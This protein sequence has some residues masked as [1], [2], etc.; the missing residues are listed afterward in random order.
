MEC[1]APVR[2]L[3]AC[4]GLLV[5]VGLAGNAAESEAEP[6][7]G[8]GWLIVPEE[9]WLAVAVVP[10]GYFRRAYDCFV[11]GSR[12]EAAREIRAKAT[13]VRLESRRAAGRAR[14]NLA[15]CVGRLKRLA[16]DIEG[17][18]IESGSGLA[19]VFAETEFR[20]AEHH[21]VKALEA[22]ASGN[23]SAMGHDISACATHLLDASTWADA[24]LAD[25]D[26]EAVDEARG[27]GRRLMRL[28]AA[29]PEPKPGALRR[30]GKAIARFA[31]R[32]SLKALPT[33][34]DATAEEDGM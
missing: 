23:R 21:Y 16:K 32:L 2:A 6:T 13:L 18:R 17:G 7:V 33:V 14:R 12:P 22:E 19:A 24:E 9:E 28:S 31:K 10:A 34:E 8:H 5:G 29:P 1:N 11:E 26:V 30:I 15:D 3:A 4:A 20:L 25:A 27:A